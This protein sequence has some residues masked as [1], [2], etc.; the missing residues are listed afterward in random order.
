MLTLCPALPQHL[1]AAEAAGSDDER[2][3]SWAAASAHVDALSAP[4]CEVAFR[5]L[6]QGAHDERGLRY[7]TLALAW[8]EHRLRLRQAFQVVQAQ[9]ALFLTLHGDQLAREKSCAPLLE[10]LQHVQRESWEHLH[11]LLQ[12]NMSLVQLFSGL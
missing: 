10:R 6:S 8:L 9:I 12:G 1:D 5:E 3:A 2:T 7:L 11:A 4:D